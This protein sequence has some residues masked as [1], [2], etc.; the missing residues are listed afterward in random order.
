VPDLSTDSGIPHYRG[1]DGLW[2]R[3]PEA[4]KLVTL[5]HCRADPE[6]RRKAERMR[7]EGGVLDA[8]PNAAHRALAELE[9]AAR[10]PS[11]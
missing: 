8:R 6:V 7:I 2:R 11:R 9:R 4:E 10:L 1:P 3:D 5:S